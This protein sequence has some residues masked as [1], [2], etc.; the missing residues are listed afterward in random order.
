MDLVTQRA[1]SLGDLQVFIGDAADMA[2]D[3]VHNL[4]YVVSGYYIFQFE[5]DRLK[6]GTLNPYSGTFD[7]T[8]ANI[9]LPTLHAVTCKDGK[10][11]F[12]ANNNGNKLY[13]IGDALN[14][15]TLTYI[16]DVDVNTISGKSEMTYDSATQKFYLT[17]AGDRLYSFTENGSD[18][19][20]IDVL[21]DG[22][23]MNGL[24]IKRSN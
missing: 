3:P 10:V 24:A 17:D 1:T 18:V 19:T 4:I 16:R 20:L 8:K 12:L 11:Y 5:V 14:T 22:W 21:G 15:S 13:S 6:P 2:Y 7:V 9:S 23:D